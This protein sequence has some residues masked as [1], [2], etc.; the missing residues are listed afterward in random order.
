MSAYSEE[1]VAAAVTALSHVCGTREA[2]NRPLKYRFCPLCHCALEKVV[3]N[4]STW[5]CPN[6]SLT[7]SPNRRGKKK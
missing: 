2:G 1:S 6:C 3:K 7:V 5:K 4:V